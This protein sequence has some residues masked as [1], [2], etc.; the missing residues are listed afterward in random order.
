M[1]HTKYD[2]WLSITRYDITIIELNWYNTLFIAWVNCWLLMTYWMYIKLSSYIRV[3]LFKVPR[4][5]SQIYHVKLEKK[6]KVLGYG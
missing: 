3:S 6:Q 4:R 5:S 2:V 1:A